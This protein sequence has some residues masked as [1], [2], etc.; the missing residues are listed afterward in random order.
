MGLHLADTVCLLLLQRVPR[1]P[2]APWALH[3]RLAHVSDWGMG[4]V[5][6]WGATLLCGEHQG[7]QVVHAPLAPVGPD[8]PDRPCNP[9]VPLLLL[10]LRVGLAAVLRL[11]RGGVVK[12]LSELHM[13][14]EPPQ[15]AALEAH[16]AR[17][18]LPHQGH[19]GREALPH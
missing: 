11:V 3:M 10:Q 15:C 17:A 4:L 7:G 1:R 18:T 12:D 5:A 2:R 6:R 14:L 13:D 9:C 8:R 16:V 19:L